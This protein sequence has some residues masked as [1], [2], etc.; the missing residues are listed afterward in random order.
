[1]EHLSELT[2]AI[3]GSRI[4]FTLE[5]ICLLHHTITFIMRELNQSQWMDYIKRQ[6]K[7]QQV[8]AIRFG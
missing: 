6:V 4:R 7:D 2:G 8:A 5:L 3:R 1:M